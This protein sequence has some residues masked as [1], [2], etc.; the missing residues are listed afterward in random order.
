MSGGWRIVGQADRDRLPSGLA[1]LLSESLEEEMSSVVVGESP[2]CPET[3]GDSDTTEIA[4]LLEPGLELRSELR[5]VAEDRCQAGHIEEEGLGLDEGTSTP[6]MFFGSFDSDDGAKTLRR[7]RQSA[8]IFD[9]LVG[10][11]FFDENL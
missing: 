2:C 6:K 4:L 7:F 8:E 9:V 5:F 11:V 1:M 10:I 3:I